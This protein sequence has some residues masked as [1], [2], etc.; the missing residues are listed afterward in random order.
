M[1]LERLPRTA[2]LVLMPLMLWGPPAVAEVIYSDF[3]DTRGLSLVG[4][5]Q[6]ADSALRLAPA[7]PSR[8]VAA[9]YAGR[10]AVKEGFSTEFSFLLRD[11]TNP[12]SPLDGFT[13]ALQDTGSSSVGEEL[14][15]GG[16]GNSVAF[17]F[18]AADFAAGIPGSSLSIL[19]GGSL[20]ASAERVFRIPDIDDGRAH[21]A[22]IVFEQTRRLSI[23][24]DDM[25]N[26]I[27][28]TV[29]T[30]ALGIQFA[31]NSAYAGFTAGNQSPTGVYDILSWRIR[32]LP[33]PPTLAL[34][35]GLAALGSLARRGCRRRQA[36]A[37]IARAVPGAKPGARHLHR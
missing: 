23:Y 32:S 6:P 7:D 15:Y 10:I 12:L 13:F 26:P 21:S 34:F 35:G 5:V 36:P 19:A 28:D 9:W 14:G 17:A 18:R 3:A 11:V 20:T 31:D 2:T 24:V 4:N 30:P 27:A 1:N 37:P 29:W 33:E 25:T 16:L 22:K 8:G